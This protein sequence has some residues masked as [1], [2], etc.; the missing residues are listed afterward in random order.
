MGTPQV[1]VS[2]LYRQTV[3]PS[4]WLNY[5]NNTVNYTAGYAGGV[6]RAL[7]DKQAETVSP[8]DFGADPT[9]VLD[10]SAAFYAAAA[11]GK[12]IYVSKGLY[13]LALPNGP[14]I[15]NNQHMHGD[16][17]NATFLRCTNTNINTTII[18]L[19]ALGRLKRMFIQ[20]MNANGTSIC[21]GAETVG[22]RVC[23]DCGAGQY[24]VQRGGGVNDVK[25]GECGTALYNANN[26]NQSVFSAE[27]YDIECQNFTFAGLWFGSPFRTG[28]VYRNLYLNSAKWPSVTSAFYL[29]GEESE[30]SID[31]INCESMVA[32]SPMVLSNIRACHIGTLHFEECVLAQNSAGLIYWNASSGMIEALT[33]YYC[34]INTTDWSIVK[35]GSIVYPGALANPSTLN[36]LQIGTFH[37]KGLNNGT[38]PNVPASPGLTGLTQIWFVERPVEAGVQYCQIDRYVWNTFLTDQAVYQ[39]FPADPQINISFLATADG[40][41]EIGQ[42]FPTSGLAPWWVRRP[43]GYLEEGGPFTVGANSTLLVTFPNPYLSQVLHIDVNPFDPSTTATYRVSATPINNATFNIV[44]TAG[45]PISGS[46]RSIGK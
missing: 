44:N 20:F 31:Q 33:V 17:Q 40:P 38:F 6:S 26:A 29:D 16:G 1:K 43:D 12:D 15:L 30:S 35:L 13:L 42:N 7:V 39:A 37:L 23:V 8:T 9:G 11:T 22:Q 18:Y 19:G 34:N 41:G 28:N 24:P 25:F 45:N 36:M 46:W 4:P 27:F 32:V 2:Y 21:T 3:I 14:I 5:V 10:S